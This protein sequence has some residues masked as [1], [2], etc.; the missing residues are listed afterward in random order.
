MK[1][2]VA[3]LL[4]DCQKDFCSPNGALFV[5]GAVEDCERLSKWIL[6]NKDEIDH[7]SCSL[8][9]HH[10]ND[11]AHPGYWKDKD[12]NHPNPFTQIKSSDI[13]NGT[14]SAIKPQ[15][16]LQY[17]RD[18]E[19]QGEYPHVIWPEHC[20]ISSVGFSMDDKVFDSLKT[21]SR[22]GKTIKFIPKGEN[23]GSEHFGIFEAQ[24]PIINA[25]GT[26]YNLPLQKKLEEHDVIYIT[27]QARNFCVINS[28]KQL[29]NKAPDLAS[30]IVILD[31]CTSNVPGFDGLGDDIWEKAKKLGVRFSTTDKEV[32]SVQHSF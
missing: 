27:G 5:P 14:W 10:V 13:E 32:L 25:T 2:K 7:V 16:A 9:S 30:K 24:V 15:T 3:L 29:I 17:L 31:D 11:I 6:D 4:I 1:K 21:W 28:L 12:G 18:L 22:G 8:D 23:P 20:L 19:S 26:Q